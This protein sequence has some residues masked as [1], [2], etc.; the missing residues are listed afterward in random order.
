[1]FVCVYVCICVWCV[2]VY[3]CVCVCV[4]AVRG[5][6]FTI[7]KEKENFTASQAVPACP[8]GARLAGNKGEALVREEGSTMRSALMEACKGGEKF[9]VWSKF[10]LSRAALQPDFGHLGR[11]QFWRKCLSSFCGGPHE[12]HLEGQ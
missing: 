2:C 9:S 7:H 1:M 10:C 6:P 11:A 8:S 3:M 5:T 4:C 12:K